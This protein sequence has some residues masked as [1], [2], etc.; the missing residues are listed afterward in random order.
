MDTIYKNYEPNKGFE[1]LQ[2]KIYNEAVKPYQGSTVTGDQI[3]N[4]ITTEKPD[5]NGINFA[6][7]PDG[8]PLAYFQF[9]YHEKEHEIYIGY[10]WSVSDCPKEVQEKLWTDELAYVKNKYPNVPLYMGYISNEYKKMHAFAKE[11]GFP[12]HD[13][14]TQYSLQI[15][16]LSQMTPEKF[17]VKVATADDLKTLVELGKADPDLGG[18]GEEQITT[19]FRDR[20]LRDGHCIIL[21]KDKLAIAACAPLKAYKKNTS[22]IRFTAIRKGNEKVR[23]ALYIYLAKHLVEVKWEEEELTLNFTPKEPWQ[24]DFIKEAKAKETSKST[25]FKVQ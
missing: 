3:K 20:V 12:V 9:R 19:Y 4:R 2:A 8:S 7:K 13:T 10:P 22:L 5:F 14:E 21:S 25:L 15:K 17:D 1:E 16:H 6:I 24:K 18:M 11:K 23:K